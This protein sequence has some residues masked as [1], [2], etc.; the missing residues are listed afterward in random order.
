MKN[1][2]FDTP[3]EQVGISSPCSEKQ[4]SVT[5]LHKVRF[6]SVTFPRLLEMLGLCSR[7]KR[8]IIQ[9]GSLFILLRHH[10]ANLSVLKIFLKSNLVCFYTTVP[11]TVTALQMGGDE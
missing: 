6:T 7:L 3:R 11:I 1:A 2:I 10:S 8:E 4:D 5:S 9:A